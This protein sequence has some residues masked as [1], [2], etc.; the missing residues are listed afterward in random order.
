MATIAACVRYLAENHFTGEIPDIKV[1]TPGYVW[2]CEMLNVSNI[3]TGL[4]PDERLLKTP[5]TC[6]YTEDEVE[7]ARWLAHYFS[8]DLNLTASRKG[9]KVWCV[10]Y[11]APLANRGA[12]FQWPIRVDEDQMVAAELGNC[13]L[14]SHPDGKGGIAVHHVEETARM[15]FFN[16]S[17]LGGPGVTRV[18]PGKSTKPADPAVR[19][20]TLNYYMQLSS[21]RVKILVRDAAIVAIRSN[22]YAVLPAH[23]GYAALRAYLNENYPDWSFIQA[24]VTNRY[25]VADVATGDKL[26]ELRRQLEAAGNEVPEDMELVFRYI[27]SD[28]TDACMQVRPYIRYKGYLLPLRLNASVKHLGDVSIETFSS[29]LTQLAKMANLGVEEITF[30][31]QMPIKS[32]AG[33][34]Q[35]V[36]GDDDDFSLGISDGVIKREMEHLPDE[37]GTGIEVFLAVLDAIKAQCTNEDNTLDV[38]SYVQRVDAASKLL[39][40]NLMIY[41]KAIKQQ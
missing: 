23:E 39:S 30:L 34:F 36:V 4:S 13:L 33:C 37:K 11:D 41:D 8:H 2:L 31:C 10:S 15:G 27:T 17:L 6:L 32:I 28:T 29:Q 20:K 18:T 14:L 5:S 24:S 3:P 19:A 7:F 9:L 16:M 1:L 35:H 12:A 40:A 38:S 22:K 26:P 21:E 25:V